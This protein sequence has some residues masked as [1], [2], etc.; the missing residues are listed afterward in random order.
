MRIRASEDYGRSGGDGDD[1]TPIAPCRKPRVR[2]G[3]PLQY[4]QPPSAPARS[5]NDTK[6]FFP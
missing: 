5:D 6:R 3:M 4:P 2:A 1:V